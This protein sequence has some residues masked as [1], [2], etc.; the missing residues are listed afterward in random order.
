MSLFSKQGDKQKKIDYI[1]R[2]LETKRPSAW[3]NFIFCL[4]CDNQRGLAEQ[5]DNE[6]V[7]KIAATNKLGMNSIDSYSFIYRKT[8]FNF[9]IHIPFCW[10]D[11]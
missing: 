10:S 1:L 11:F 8:M 5:I 7:K 3:P 9:S 6:L 4:L 2:I